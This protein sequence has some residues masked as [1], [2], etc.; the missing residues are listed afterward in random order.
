MMQTTQSRTLSIFGT[1]LIL[2][3]I[4]AFIEIGVKGRN[5]MLAGILTGVIAWTLSW[6]MSQKK[7]SI[8][9]GLGLSF[10]CCMIYG[11]RA[12]ANLLALIGIIQHEMPLDAYN[13][14]IT[15]VI[16]LFMS[17][18]SLGSLMMLFSTMQPNE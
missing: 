14:C 3:G 6:Y 4:I 18:A 10:S 13:K 17:M 15:I 12:I 2:S 11:Q 8:W 9:L 7:I 1:I 16:L 5:L